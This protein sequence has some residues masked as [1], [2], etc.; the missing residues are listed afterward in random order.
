M[1]YVIGVSGKA[2][3]GKDS[4]VDY[5]QEELAARGIASDRF[6]FAKGVKLFGERYFGEICD[7][8]VK[9]RVS[10]LVLQGI[11]QM[12]R[13]EVSSQYWVER[14]RERITC[15]AESVDEDL[16]VF[17]TD[18]RY[19]NEADSLI[20]EAGDFNYRE[21]PEWKASIRIKGRTSLTGAA[22]E[23][24]SET[25]LDDYPEKNFTAIYENLGTLEELYAF[26]RDFLERNVY[27]D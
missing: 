10:R 12:M 17:I 15:K 24:I 4:L 20:L 22:A 1:L 11:G 5:M 9:D 26:G 18:V 8:V 14:A 16:V 13:A 27:N 25:D 19:K 7:P 2:G 21:L 3:A 6:A 23:H